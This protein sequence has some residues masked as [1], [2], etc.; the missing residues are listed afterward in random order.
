MNGQG[1][2]VIAI[3]QKIFNA[4]QIA[5]Y[6]FYG[7]WT[8]DGI[9]HRNTCKSDNRITNLRLA[10]NSENH[11]NVSLTAANTSGRKG[12]TW[13]KK[14]G[15]WHAQ[16]KVNGKNKYLGLYSNIDEAHNAYVLAANENFGEFAR[17]A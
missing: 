10:S 5:W 16:I 17:T 2:N 4:H 15:K 12:V 8:S 7:E 13:N 14:C 3:D 6:L 9:D 11:A 1:Y